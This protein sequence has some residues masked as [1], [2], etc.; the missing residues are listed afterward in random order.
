LANLIDTL[1]AFRHQASDWLVMARDDDLFPS[2]Y[3]VEQF[4]EMGFRFECADFRHCVPPSKLT[5][6]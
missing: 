5:S 6:R 1:R 4:A 3:A 2:R